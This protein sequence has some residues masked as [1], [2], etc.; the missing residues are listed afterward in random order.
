MRVNNIIETGVQ[1]IQKMYYLRK[2][3]HIVMKEQFSPLFRCNIKNSI[4]PLSNLP[5]L[6]FGVVLKKTGTLRQQVEKSVHYL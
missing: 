6:Y 5:L 4:R 2:T 3:N 1:V